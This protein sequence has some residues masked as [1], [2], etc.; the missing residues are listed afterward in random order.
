MNVNP[1]AIRYK[2][3]K[4]KSISLRSPALQFYNFLSSQL[5]SQNTAFINRSI[6][7]SDGSV[8]NANLRKE[9]IYGN[10]FGNIL[11]STSVSSV[12]GE[13]H[14]LVFA[15]V[16]NSGH[17]VYLDEE[18][19]TLSAFN[20]EKNIIG[21]YPNLI[22]TDASYSLQ[23]TGQ[24]FS[25]SKDS[26][27]SIGFAKY[28]LTDDSEY[29]TITGGSTDG[30]IKQ[31]SSRYLYKTG[32]SIIIE[33]KQYAINAIVGSWVIEDPSVISIGSCLTI[34]S[35]NPKDVLLVVGSFDNFLPHYVFTGRF[36]DGTWYANGISPILNLNSGGWCNRLRLFNVTTT[37]P[38]KDA[39]KGLATIGTSGYL[40]LP[41]LP[42]DGY[43]VFANITYNANKLYFTKDD[44]Y[45]TLNKLVYASVYRITGDQLFSQ[46]L[47]ISSITVMSA[48]LTTGLE[49]SLV[50]YQLTEENYIH[51]NGSYP[52]FPFFNRDKNSILG[53]IEYITYE[54]SPGVRKD[55]ICYLRKNAGYGSQY[56]DP[57]VDGSY[58]NSVTE[59]IY[60]VKIDLSDNS[61]NQTLIYVT[62]FAEA[63]YIVSGA[64]TTIA[65]GSSDHVIECYYADFVNDVF[66]LGKILVGSDT[67]V[68]SLGIV[69]YK[70]IKIENGTASTLDT[71]TADISGY[72]YDRTFIAPIP[73][74]SVYS[75]WSLWGSFRYLAKDKTGSMGT[76][77]PFSLYRNDATKVTTGVFTARPD[78]GDFSDTYYVKT[79]D[80]I[81]TFTKIFDASTN[82]M[83]QYPFITNLY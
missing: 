19:L 35:Y 11:I 64:E 45:N 48:G 5:K 2:G 40:T 73:Y 33:G 26:A 69:P 4:D 3:D 70:L 15:F 68:G 63:S 72:N 30:L 12:S 24:K 74:N 39:S 53:N 21:Y 31:A 66:V 79:V 76:K 18:T 1:P 71:K 14:K 10:I 49:T 81:T 16:D 37:T 65:R 20:T 36:Y 51:W 78:R 60:S 6:V 27:V 50:G 32:F 83:E 62:T 8:I 7:L 44:R 28:S 29:S 9:G 41:N 61:V 67:P 82:N 55:Y 52:T 58:S 23:F 25:Y 77:K 13:R 57:T 46:Y 47:N 43:I 80:G 42:L 22:T 56:V 59:G 75:Q 38:N 54:E 34:S 17:W